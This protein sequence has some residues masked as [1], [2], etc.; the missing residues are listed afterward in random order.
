[1]YL[2]I[3]ERNDERQKQMPWAKKL[4]KDKA[5]DKQLKLDAQ[6]RIRRKHLVDSAQ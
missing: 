2:F 4:K 1:M 6:N 3:A 5:N